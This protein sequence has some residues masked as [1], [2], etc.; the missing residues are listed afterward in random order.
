MHPGVWVI[1]SALAV[2][3]SLPVLLGCDMTNT[4]VLQLAAVLLCAYERCA[5]Y[6]G[7]FYTSI[8]PRVE[9]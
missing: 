5:F 2:L 4:Y 1:V 9:V 6:S 3:G 8:D 7:I